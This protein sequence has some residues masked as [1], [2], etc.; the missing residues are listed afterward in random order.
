MEI[1]WIHHT[2]IY[3]H[4]TPIRHLPYCATLNNTRSCECISL[5]FTRHSR[6]IHEEHVWTRY[7]HARC[8]WS[9][10]SIC[11]LWPILQ[12][13]FANCDI[14]LHSGQSPGQTKPVMYTELHQDGISLSL[15]FNSLQEQQAGKYTCRGNY[16][17][18]VPLSKSVTI[19][20][21]SEYKIENSV[22]F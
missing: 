17:R 15:F 18:N 16:A 5:S 21:I 20:T 9:L 8:H 4:H 6:V 1:A 3:S 7:H 22:A 13:R 14:I 2:I 10:P 19:D 11:V 12:N